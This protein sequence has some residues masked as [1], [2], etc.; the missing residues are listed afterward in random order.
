MSPSSS[1]GAVLDRDGKLVG[2]AVAALRDTAGLNVAIAS[3]TVEAFLS[4]VSGPTE[5]RGSPGVG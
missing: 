1:G 5:A 3:E 2:M 4:G